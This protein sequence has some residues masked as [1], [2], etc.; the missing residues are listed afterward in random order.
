MTPKRKCENAS[1]TLGD[2]NKRK[3]DHMGD[4]LPSITRLH[5]NPAQGL[6]I[7][8]DI[9]AQC[10]GGLMMQ[11]FFGLEALNR[12]ISSEGVNANFESNDI[13]KDKE[14]VV[15]VEILEPSTQ[16][17]ETN[18][19]GWV[20]VDFNEWA[21]LRLFRSLVSCIARYD[22]EGITDCFVLGVG[23]ALRRLVGELGKHRDL[24]SERVCRSK[25]GKMEVRD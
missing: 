14:V 3:Q 6:N 23:S 21:R 5:L 4:N 13:S 15:A 18:D 1:L 24:L 25:E 2:P 19:E 12:R 11:V 22:D 7:S 9:S 16:A 17:L 10:I 20:Q 8:L